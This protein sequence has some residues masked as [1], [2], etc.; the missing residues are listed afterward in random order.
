MIHPA[1]AAWRR[2]HRAVLATFSAAM[3][4]VVVWRLQ[5]LDWAGAW[6]AAQALPITALAAAAVVAVLGHVNYGAF[7]LLAKR[8]IG[9]TVPAWRMGWGGT[10][11]YAF[12]LNFG[13]MIG[14]AAVRWRLLAAAGVS[15]ADTTRVVTLAVLTNWLGYAAVTSLLLLGASRPPMPHH[16]ATL[17]AQA[18]GLGMADLQAY[19]QHLTAWLT[20]PAARWAGL[21]MLAAVLAWLAVLAWRNQPLA[22]LQRA[23]LQPPARWLPVAQISLGASNWLWMAG[24]MACL[25]GLQAVHPV[26]FA[27]VL[28]A[29]LLASLAGLVARVPGGLGVVEAVYLVMLGPQ[30]DAHLLLGAL[31]VFRA[32]YFIAPLLA[33]LPGYWLLARRPAR[34]DG[35]ASAR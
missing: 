14:G 35:V 2:W 28:G 27:Q 9:L 13:S 21:A 10:V 33:A 20:S 34:D 23:G 1:R 19:A 22:K 6:Q 30:V 4:G 26:P 11:S 32:L 12:T 8:W 29:Q 7:D 31:L 15:T 16:A 17:P 24:V 25:L 18:S 5:S 3:L